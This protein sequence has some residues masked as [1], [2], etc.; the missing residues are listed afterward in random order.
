MTSLE[1]RTGGMVKSSTTH[2]PKDTYL[3]KPPRDGKKP[4]IMPRQSTDIDL[5]VLVLPPLHRH[6]KRGR[7]RN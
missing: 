3:H 5:Y 4:A 1:Y 6:K 7:S 2:A